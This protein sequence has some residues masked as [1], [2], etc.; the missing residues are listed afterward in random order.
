MPP[1]RTDLVIQRILIR[2][3]FTRQMANQL[4][5][6]MESILDH[7]AQH[8]PEQMPAL[9]FAGAGSSGHDHSGR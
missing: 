8:S 3:G 5:V 4:L 1:N 7:L 6:E 9:A 2:H